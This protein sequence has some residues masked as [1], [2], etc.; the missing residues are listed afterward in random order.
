MGRWAARKTHVKSHI[1]RT[2]LCGFLVFLAV[3]TFTAAIIVRYTNDNI[4]DSEAY[5]KIVGSLPQNPEVAT[6]LGAFTADRL[7]NGGTVE[8]YMASFL[9]EKL[10]PAAPLLTETLKEQV[11]STASNVV[12]SDK[13]TEI[14]S[15]ANR[16]AHEALLA[17][18]HSEPRQP[19]DDAS[20]NLK[21]D[22]LFALVRERFRGANDS[23][24][25]DQQKQ[26]AADLVIN[27]RQNVQTFR[28]VVQAVET[29]AWLLPVVGFLLLA[30]AI[31]AANNRRLAVLG[32][33]ISLA[34][35]GLTLL[36]AF[37]LIS[38]RWLNSFEQS[39]YR[40]AAQ[41]VY[42][43]FYGN[44]RARLVAITVTGL[45]IVLI[46]LVFSPYKWAVRLREVLRL[47]T[48]QSR[49]R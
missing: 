36:L 42:E 38:Q 13:F 31:W 34:A 47:D 20:A 14:W 11:A 4:L 17:V 5:V 21:L 19:K 1:W 39:V 15:Q 49:K 33:G 29:G 16:S 12:A 24:L 26:G 44:L 10:A 9:P 25:N 27:V 45:I 22:G 3:C 48:L 43:A 35:L 37:R 40:D 28:G 18:A 8:G 23:L 41:V 32:I 7:F 2:A 6:A 46:T 30:G